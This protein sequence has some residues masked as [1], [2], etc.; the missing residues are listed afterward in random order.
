MPSEEAFSHVLRIDGDQITE[1]GQP[2]LLK[3]IGVVGWLNFEN[4][5][6]GFPGHEQGHRDAVAE[7]LGAERA[8]F[9]FERFVTHFFDDADA[10]FIAEMGFNV[11]RI[12][13]HYRLFE[14]DDRPMEIK[15]KGFSYLD[16]AVSMCARHGVRTILD[17]H[18]LPG[19]QNQDWHCDNPTHVATFWQHRH[20][21][22]RVVNLW[23]AIA[24]HYR[25]DARIAAYNPVNEPA[26]PT[27][28]V[29]AQFSRE[30]VAQIRDVDPD[31]IIILEGNRYAK[32]FDLLGDPMPNVLYS[33]HEY[34][35]PAFMRGSRYPGITHL[36]QVWT[37]TDGQSHEFGG[38]LPGDSKDQYFDKATLERGFRER[39][40][41]MIRTGTP[42]FVGEF[43]AIFTG[44]P[45]TDSE[46]LTLLGDQFDIYTKHSASWSFWPYKDIG[47]CA[48]VLVDPDSTWIRRIRPVLEKKA[49][50]GVDRWGGN[51]DQIMS[52]M[53]PLKELFAR[54]FPGYSPFPFGS[55][56]LIAR[57][58]PEILF[59]EAMQA[60]FA[61]CFRDMPEDEIDEMMRS[62]RLENCVIRQPLASLLR[63]ACAAGAPGPAVAR[64]R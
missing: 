21:Q 22:D 62:F 8:E 32:E 12:P 51:H 1:G 2:V 11:V 13:F 56:D 39:S 41:Y 40:E 54:E 4:W 64:Q 47:M 29:F 42:V 60:D 15:E 25:G 52:V 53:G 31:H 50:L 61:E 33:I 49:R 37:S 28:R 34:P 48:P 46:R 57:M 18:T 63:S 26:D 35:P 44:N 10:A 16:R 36:T 27:E 59:A 38:L 58:V 55:D 23:R 17:L 5:I 9:F 14:D 30:I 45:V 19:W 7:V 6:T 24:E 20:F 3:G 43:N